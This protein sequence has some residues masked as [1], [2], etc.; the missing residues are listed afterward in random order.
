[1]EHESYADFIARVHRQ[2]VEQGKA[3]HRPGQ[4]KTCDEKRALSGQEGTT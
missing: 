2:D 4:C 1:M 3:M